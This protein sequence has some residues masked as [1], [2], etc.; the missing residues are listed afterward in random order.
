MKMLQSP[1]L[2]YKMNKLRLQDHKGIILQDQKEGEF[3]QRSYE[4]MVPPSYYRKIRIQKLN[5]Y[6]TIKSDSY[7][8]VVL[9]NPRTS[10]I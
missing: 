2:Y 1:E 7:F 3:D 5:L 6:L 9:D 8:I 4:A 10:R